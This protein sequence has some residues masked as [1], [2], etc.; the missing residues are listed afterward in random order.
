GA[1][2]AGVACWGGTGPGQPATRR[3]GGLGRG[4]GGAEGGSASGDGL[5]T[6]WQIYGHYS[7]GRNVL[8]R[9]L[10][11]TGTIAAPVR[12]KALN[13]LGV[14]LWSQN[15]TRGLEPVADEALALAQEQGDH[16]QMTVA[17]ILRGVGKMREGRDYAQAQV[18][19][20]EAL[21]SARV[22]GDRFLL[23]S[24]LLSLGLLAWY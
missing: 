21:A 5:G 7:E 1:G 18:R 12:L 10:A 8:E 3:P 2:P 9:L 24:A 19:L 11:G 13:T 6:F 14:I 23:L 22:L 16:W 20:E 15:D 17:P 4:C